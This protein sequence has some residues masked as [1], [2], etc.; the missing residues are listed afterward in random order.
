MFSLK[1]DSTV[2]RGKLGFKPRM[3]NWTGLQG[4]SEFPNPVCIFFFL[5]TLSLTSKKIS[6]YKTRLK[7]PLKLQGTGPR[8]VYKHNHQDSPFD[9]EFY[10]L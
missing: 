2:H 10:C 4:S 9:A 7:V 5:D 3:S 8:S 6:F 1:G